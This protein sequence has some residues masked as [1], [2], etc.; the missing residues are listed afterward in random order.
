MIDATGVSCAL[1]LSRV[2][3]GWSMSFSKPTFWS[4]AKFSVSYGLPSGS[5]P[6]TSRFPEIARRIARPSSAE[7]AAPSPSCVGATPKAM[8]PGRFVAYIRAASTT[9]AAGTPVISSV[10]SGVHSAASRRT[11]SKP[12]HHSS[13]KALSYRSSS[14][15]TWTMPSASAP[16]VRGRTARWRS[17]RAAVFVTRGS[18]TISFAPCAWQSLSRSQEG[19]EDSA[20]F[21]PQI[22]THLLTPG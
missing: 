22:T 13:T 16:S 11:S 4:Q 18:I 6:G 20:G 7:R 19:G 15:I 9:S 21:E 10:R 8:R 3:S 1:T 12:R 17:A 5:P 2:R 14:I